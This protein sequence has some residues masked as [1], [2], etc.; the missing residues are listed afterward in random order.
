MSLLNQSRLSYLFTRYANDRCTES[1]RLELMDLVSMA[2]NAG[3]LNSLIEM[4]IASATTDKTITAQRADE[5]FQIILSAKEPAVA[6]VIKIFPWRRVAA[7][8]IIILMLGAGSYFLFFNKST[9][10]KFTLSKVEGLK[11][12]ND[13]AP[14]GN[15]AILTLSN[16]KQIILDSA[17]NGTITQ[18]GNT[19]IIKLDSGQLAYSAAGSPLGVGGEAGAFN[20]ITTPRGG[21]YQI[22]LADG[23]KVWLNSASSL[24]YPTAFAGK[25]R[26]VELTGEG[27]FEVAHNAA[28]PFKVLVNGIEVLDLG[29]HF[30]INAYDDESS[31]KTTLLEGSVKVTLSPETV[32]LSPSKGESAGVRLKPGQQ[33]Q[34]TP[35]Q[36]PDKSG[37]A[38][39]VSVQTVDLNEVIAWK[40][41]LFEFNK[42][43]LQTIMRQISRWYD[44]DVVYEGKPNDNRF[45][46]GIS[47]NLPLSN[48]L[49]LLEANGVKFTLEGKVL[50]VKP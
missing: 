35:E 7:A 30:N 13:V 43:D 11:G 40:K 6:P 50:K 15:K 28:K 41:G 19:K 26:N 10:S 48:V 5:I 9:L 24:K 27:Y 49:K 18:Q 12:K 29:T 17:A 36:R 14:G 31:I 46:G 44:V 33:A 39:G 8:A 16:G 20:T 42:T 37:G 22:I 23:S 25:E 21:Q 47:K 4:E 34:V 38:G 1:E 45:G 32:T 3:E 2:E